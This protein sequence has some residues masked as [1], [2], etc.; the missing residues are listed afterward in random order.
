MTVI[1]GIAWKDG[2]IHMWWDKLGSAEWRKAVYNSPKVF[3]VGKLLIWYSWSNVVGDNL[4]YL[5]N[6]PDD[7]SSLLPEEDTQFEWKDFAEMDDGELEACLDSKQFLVRKIIPIIK[8]VL[9]ESDAAVMDKKVQCL[10]MDASA[11]IWYSNKLYHLQTDFSLLEVADGME[12]IWDGEDTAWWYLQ[13]Q[14][15]KAKGKL[16][17]RS[18]EKIK[19]VITDAIEITSA[20]VQSVSS[21]SM[22]LTLEADKIRLKIKH[23]L[24]EREKER[25][26]ASKKTR[27]RQPVAK[28]DMHS[29][30][31]TPPD[32][33]SAN[34]DTIKMASITWETRGIE[35]PNPSES[36]IA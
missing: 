31:E 2:R 33:G 28:K 34:N 21:E 12:A 26:D 6:N 24:L 1:I 9:K 5:L 11:L 32:Q 17:S 27:R 8:K 14:Q 29:S 20:K 30:E 13:N 25:L 7:P 22:I 19:E 16:Q 36:S 35:W 15:K 3:K 10:Q 18:L 23:I 4:H